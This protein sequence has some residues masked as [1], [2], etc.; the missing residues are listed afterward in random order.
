MPRKSHSSEQI[1]RKLREVEEALA[2]A[3]MSLLNN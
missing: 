1:L 2:K 3:E